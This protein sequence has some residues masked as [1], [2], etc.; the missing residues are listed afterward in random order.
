M[1]DRLRQI[2]ADARRAVMTPEELA[3]QKISF[4]HGNVAIDDPRVT[5]ELVVQCYLEMLKPPLDR[6]APVP[7]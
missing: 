5:R 4:A 7:E 3:A 6:P 2:I 1:N